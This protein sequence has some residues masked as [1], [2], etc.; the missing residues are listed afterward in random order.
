MGC[1]VQC[2]VIKLHASQ[3]AAVSKRSY[4]LPMEHTTQP[5]LSYTM[6]LR[7]YLNEHSPLLKKS[8][9]ARIQELGGWPPEI[10]DHASIRHCL[11]PS[12][13]QIL[14]SFEGT[15]DLTASTV[16]K[17]QEYK[18]EDIYI[19]WKLVE[20]M[21]LTSVQKKKARK[22][23]V[24]LDHKLIQYIMPQRSGGEESIGDRKSESNIVRFLEYAAG[25]S[26]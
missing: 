21:R 5:Y 18:L 17:L 6:Y 1:N 11:S 12:V 19:G 8:V 22:T 15:S 13:F 23:G 2:F 26:G 3:E 20:V 14:V 4:E 10:N 16:F 24:L 9:R 7:S 25:D